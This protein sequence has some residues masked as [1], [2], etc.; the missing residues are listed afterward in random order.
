MNDTFYPHARAIL[1]GKSTLPQTPEEQGYAKIIDLIRKDE[2]AKIN[3]LLGQWFYRHLFT[4]GLTAQPDEDFLALM[5][6]DLR[7]NT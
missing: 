6:E 4:L 1:D 5:E 3:K 7:S 2:R